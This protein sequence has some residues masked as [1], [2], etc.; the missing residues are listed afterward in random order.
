MRKIALI[1]TG[2][3]I[4]MRQNQRGKLAPM[5]F[6]SVAEKIPALQLL[7]IEILPVTL[8]N[9]IDSSE[10]VPKVWQELAEVIDELMDRVDGMVVLHGTD[11]MAYTACALSFMIEGLQKPIIITG[12]QLPVGVL[13]TDAVENIVSAFEFAALA[14][15]DGSAVIQEVA[16][17]FEYEL[18]R[19][20]RAYKRSSNEFNAFS[21]P[22][23]PP[24][25]SSGVRLS[26]NK[27]LLWR[28]EKLY[29]LRSGIDT[30]VGVVTLY[31]GLDFDQLPHLPHWKVLVLRTFGAGN[32]PKSTSFLEFLKRVEKN[33]TIIV[34]TSQCVSGSV[35]PGLYDSSS[36]LEEV[37]MLNAK[38]MTFESALVKSMVLLGQSNSVADFHIK[39]PLSLAGEVSE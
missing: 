10:M 11:T 33:G 20:N 32:A 14:D 19:G 30:N 35:L 5:D 37:K 34:N 15:E 24:L 1:Y 28:S 6:E 38:D 18:L 39:F 7:P 29:Q 26:V 36:A 3:T 22:N 23:Y 9:P 2:G 31:P 4:G 17:Y 16:I 27:E 13:R 8:E 12:S 25:A 21:S